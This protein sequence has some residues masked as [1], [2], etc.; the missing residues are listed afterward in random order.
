ML[1][2]PLAAVVLLAATPSQALVR[3]DVATAFF[4]APEHGSEDFAPGLGTIGRSLSIDDIGGCEGS[5]ETGERCGAY[6]NSSFTLTLTESGFAY[7]TG[8]RQD[9]AIAS[10]DLATDIYVVAAFRADREMYLRPHELRSLNLPFC[11]SCSHS[12]WSNIWQEQDS[13]GSWLAFIE[14]GTSAATYEGIQQV[15]HQLTVNL[16]EVPE[17]QAWAMLI[18]GFGLV[19]AAQRRRRALG[20]A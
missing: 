17:P 18:A 15:G 6:E 20:V 7:T 4:N 14:V 10:T 12:F 1:R 13:D 11:L 8:L 19:G 9:H 16:A 2:L 5:D 3:L